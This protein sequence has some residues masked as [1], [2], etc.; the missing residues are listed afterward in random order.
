MRLQTL[1]EAIDELVVMEADWGGLPGKS[2]LK[3]TADTPED[4]IEDIKLYKEMREDLEAIEQGR[5][6]KAKLDI[7]PDEFKES[8][9]RR[10]R[11][12]ISPRKMLYVY[13]QALM[14][15]IS[16]FMKTLRKNLR[17]FPELREV[18]AKAGIG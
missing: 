16:V 6:D 5:D 14:D 7:I 4:A 1:N 18:Y 8:Y 10:A 11:D 15:S 13:K 2:E 9:A 17:K 12:R 3:E